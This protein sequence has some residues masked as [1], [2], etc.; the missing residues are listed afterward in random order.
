MDYKAVPTC[1]YTSPEIASVGLSEEEAVK[2]RYDISVG[3]FSYMANGRALTL[4]EKEGF[5]KIISDRGTDEILG[6]HILGP[7]AT[8][9]IGEAVIA[10]RLEC[11][12]EELGKTIHAI[13]L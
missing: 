12:S 9:L 3:K 6:V 10:I 5:V 13:P 4:G 8:D 1:V 2:N 7:N 11:T